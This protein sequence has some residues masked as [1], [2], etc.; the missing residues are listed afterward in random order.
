MR[1]F[2]IFL[3]LSFLIMSVQSTRDFSSPKSVVET[4]IKASAKMDKD[5][6]SECFS[7]FAPSEWDAF[8]NKTVSKSDLK[9]LKD[10]VTDATITKTEIK[11]DNEAVVFVTFKSRD[12]QIHTVREGGRW[13]ISDF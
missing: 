10:F 6:L 12:E 9:E 7:K 5:V 2:A 3:F 13:F 11:N 4:F 8:R 1:N